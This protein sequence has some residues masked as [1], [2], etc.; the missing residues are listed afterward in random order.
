MTFHTSE[1]QVVVCSLQFILKSGFSIRDRSIYISGFQKFQ[2]FQISEIS[3]ISDIYTVSLTSDIFV[4]LV[5]SESKIFQAHYP[6]WICVEHRS[7]EFEYGVQQ[8]SQNTV[9][10]RGLAGARV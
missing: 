7:S 6:G 9:Q 2:K 8:S 3:K 1:G 10:L 5:F 4:I